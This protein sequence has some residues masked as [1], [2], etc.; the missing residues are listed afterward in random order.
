MDPKITEMDDSYANGGYAAMD[1]SS[2]VVSLPAVP[3]TD[4]G[5]SISAPVSTSPVKNVTVYA[6]SINPVSYGNDDPIVAFDV[7]FSVGIVCPD[8]GATK[9]YQVVKRIGVDR[10]KMATDAESTTPVS[11]VEAKKPMIEGMSTARFKHLAG[12]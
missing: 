5:I 11:I 8:S 6:N 2:Q 12:L 7:V 3:M 1:T 4:T 9:T 10:M